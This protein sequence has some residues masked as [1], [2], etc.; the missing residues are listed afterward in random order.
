[1]SGQA[2]NPELD[3]SLERTARLQMLVQDTQFKVEAIRQASQ[4]L[5]A[6]SRALTVSSRRLAAAS[7]ADIAA[8]KARPRN[9]CSIFCSSGSMME[10]QS[11]R[12]RRV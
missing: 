1:M 5:M 12:K 8:F 3:A 10:L 11:E 9:Y 7:Q 6:A 2:R 4:A